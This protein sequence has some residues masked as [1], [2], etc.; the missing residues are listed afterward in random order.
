MSAIGQLSF[1]RATEVFIALKL[2]FAN[3]HNRPEADINVEL[4]GSALLRSPG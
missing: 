4:T 1:L 2:S 3:R